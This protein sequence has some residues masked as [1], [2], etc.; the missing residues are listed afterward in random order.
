[1]YIPIHT[2]TSFQSHRDCMFIENVMFQPPSDSEGVGYESEWC[3][4]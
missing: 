4:L 2:Q 3:F 1:M